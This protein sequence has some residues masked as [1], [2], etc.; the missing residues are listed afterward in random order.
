M[1]SEDSSTDGTF[2]V[3]FNMTPSVGGINFRKFSKRAV[4]DLGQTAQLP[5]RFRTHT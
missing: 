5:L 4:L 1:T 2:S 3:A